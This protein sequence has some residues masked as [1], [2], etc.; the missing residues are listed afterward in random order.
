MNYH[1][2]SFCNI[3]NKSADCFGFDF[4]I[5]NL[6][7][8][9]INT[10]R[11]LFILSLPKIISK[12]LQ[13]IQSVYLGL[14]VIAMSL[15]F[16]FSITRYTVGETTYYFDVFGLEIDGVNVV[17]IPFYIIAAVIAVLALIT[18]FLYGN[19]QNQLRLGMANFVFLLVFV[20]LVYWFSG[21]VVAHIPKPADVPG[22]IGYGMGF[23]MPIAALAFTF[24]ANRAIRK[25]ENL[26]KSLDRLR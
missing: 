14:A 15:M 2:N 6:I 26:V 19:R 8:R 3:T 16:A 20:G 13:R 1:P 24:L 5:E 25:D 4:F 7:H 21:S 23:F 9:F 22:D 11:L 12:M 10:L 18:I 17:G